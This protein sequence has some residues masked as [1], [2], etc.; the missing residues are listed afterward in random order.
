MRNNNDAD[1]LFYFPL[2]KSKWE[3]SYDEKINSKKQQNRII[4]REM[5]KENRNREMKEN[6]NREKK[7]NRNR[8]MKDKRNCKRKESYYN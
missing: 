8:K 1:R 3:D 6:R 4:N 2:K 5:K 7:E